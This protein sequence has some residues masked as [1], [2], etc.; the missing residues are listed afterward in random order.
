MGE[1]FVK[2]CIAIFVILNVIMP[3]VGYHFYKVICNE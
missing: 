1:I 2:L 3:L